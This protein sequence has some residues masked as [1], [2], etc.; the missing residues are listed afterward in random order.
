MNKVVYENKEDARKA[1]FEMEK[2][3]LV[4]DN[5]GVLSK[6]YNTLLK[7]RI[8]KIIASYKIKVY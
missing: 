1:A 6:K 4:L 2:A 5:N 8:R 7:K 3:R